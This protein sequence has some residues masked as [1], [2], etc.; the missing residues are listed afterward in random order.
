MC[1]ESA[2]T[3][4]STTANHP[5]TTILICTD[6]KSLCEALLSSNSRMFFIHGSI[7]SISSSMD[8]QWIS[9]RS[10][11]PGNE[12]V[13]KAVKEA[14]T[15]TTNQIYRPN[16]SIMLSWRTKFNTLALRLS[17]KWRHKTMSV[18]AR[19]VPCSGLSLSLGL[20]WCTQGRPWSTLTFNQ[21]THTREHYPYNTT[22]S[23]S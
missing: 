8:I 5:S 6:S 4:T 3:R 22:S 2:L 16:H 15:I 9:G 1:M 19:R 18:W 10:D 14:T 12:L 7:N 11:N 17:G 21:N 13:N 23:F 20:W